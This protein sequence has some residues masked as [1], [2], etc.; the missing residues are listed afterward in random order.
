MG[1]ISADPDDP[2]WR[3]PGGGG[4]A[5][6][7]IAS[8]LARPLAVAIGLLAAVRR[9]RAFHPAGST[10]GAEVEIHDRPH[11]LRA[12]AGRHRAVVRTSRGAGLPAV[13]PDVH[14]V[15]VRLVAPDA[16]PGAADPETILDLLLSSAGSG[17]VTR[18]LLR[19]GRHPH[20]ATYSSLAPY[21]AADGRRFVVGA[22]FRDGRPDLGDLLV[23]RPGGP[24]REVGVVTV[25][26]ARPWSDDEGLRFD[27]FRCPPW[28]EPVGAVNRLRQPAYRASQ[29]RRP[30]RRE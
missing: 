8:H 21:A 28:M 26:L 4:T 18:H 16:D 5:I 10:C 6:D 3:R 1:G 11:P 17:R 20:R 25:D 15:A 14:G 13:L 30:G 9:A 23:A 24:W 29:A 19:P 22:R 12:L 7:T 27:P 2:A